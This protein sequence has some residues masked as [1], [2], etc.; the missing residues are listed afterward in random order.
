M[1]HRLEGR[2]FFSR[3]S[4]TSL[5]GKATLALPRDGSVSPKRQEIFTARPILGACLA[6]AAAA[7]LLPLVRAEAA[8]ERSIIKS[9]EGGAALL[10]GRYDLAVL[11]YDEALREPGLPPARQASIYCDRGVAKWRLKQLDAALADLT[12]AVS[13]SPEYAPAYNNRGTVYME[14]NRIED[15]HKDFD[16]AIA[17]SP[18]F[19]AA[20]NNR[21]N[22][23]Q[24]LKRLDAAAADFRKAI[25]IMPTSAIPHNGRG[26][27]ASALGRYYTSLRYLNRAIT[28]NAQYAPA[29]RNRAMV[30]V[31][32]NRDEEAIQDFDKVVALNP[33]K[34]DIYVARGEAHARLKHGP[35]AT[36]DFDKALELSP[37]YGPAVLGRASQNI[38]RKR[39]DLAVEDLNR[40]L[41]ADPKNAKA[42]FWRGQ[43]R[44]A[45]NDAD[46]ADLDLGKAIELSPAFAEAYRV[47]G[48]L[49]DRAGRHDDAV[50]DYRQ[51]LE[52]DPLSRDL[53]EAYKT[54]SGDTADSV[55]KPLAPAIDGWEIFRVGGN[56][57]TALNERYPKSPVPLEMEGEGAPEILEWTPL[58]DTLAGIGLLRYRAGERNG[59]SFEDVVI[60]D[61]TR[62]QVISIEPYISGANKSKWAWTQTSV[63]VTDNDGLTSYYELKKQRTDPGRRDDNPFSFLSGGRAAGRPGLFSWFFR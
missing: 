58:K 43:A 49:R 9:Q 44:A 60:L 13:L 48:A 12:K 29:Y 39:P 36:R 41:A 3:V 38:D 57:F 18:G 25:E 16:R 51:A 17:L 63:T 21:G 33:D 23:N 47:R 27:I 45:L 22:A 50:A 61:L 1:R 42:Y 32:L 7:G 54:A 15:A 40:M 35:L 8:V 28:L 52:L 46:G 62:G 55:V 5:A 14:L 37:D 26:K 6:A 11:A 56:E 59:A 30:L 34:P 10:R 2:W 31:A 20:Y 24:K 4:R 19:G 53:R